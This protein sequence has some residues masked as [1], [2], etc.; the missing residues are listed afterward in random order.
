MNRRSQKGSVLLLV[1]VIIAVLGLLAIAG[2]NSATFEQNM[3]SND[4]QKATTF[5]AAESGLEWAIGGSGELT[6]ASAAGVGNSVTSSVDLTADPSDPA[7]TSNT[8][9]TYNSST[10]GRLTKG[11]GGAGGGKVL[12]SSLQFTESF[13]FT[14]QARGGIDGTSSLSTHVRTVEDNR[15]MSQN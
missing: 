10:V 12:D 8:T 9:V 14:V 6:R 3:A 4:A 15:L 1:L 13:Y 5:Q 11:V 7:V 2:L